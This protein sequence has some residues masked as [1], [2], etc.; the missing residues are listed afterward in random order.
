M[1][2]KL[3][4]ITLLELLIAI[5]LL[6]VIVL[7]LGSIDLFS[8]SH[9]ISSD[10][11]AKIDND[12]SLALAHMGKEIAKAIG[13]VKID[14]TTTDGDEIIKTDGISGDTAIKVYIDLDS[15][16]KSAGDGQR[17]SPPD[18]WIAYRYRP[19]T[20]TP[21]SD[22][23]QIWYCP[24]C[25]T[26]AC[27]TCVPDWNT[28]AFINQGYVLSKKITAV[29]YTSHFSETPPKNYVDTQITACWDPAQTSYSCGTPNNPSVTMKAKINML[30]VSTN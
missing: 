14:K 13:N 19:S 11:R 18:R 4:S 20:A 5:L 15:D 7:G 2:R 24:N 29:T 8:R 12:I 10:H 6:S 1:N 30:A 17:G 3:S 22:R 25:T 21:N 26:S 16:G 23:Y 28:T 9:V 27:T